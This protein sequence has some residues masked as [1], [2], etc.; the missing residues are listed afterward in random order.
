MAEGS[1]WLLLP[2]HQLSGR[3]ASFPR[4]FQHKPRDCLLVLPGPM[5]VSADARGQEPTPGAKVGFP[6]ERGWGSAAG[7]RSSCYRARLML[8]PGDRGQRVACGT[9]SQRQ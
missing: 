1:L 2:A 7:G 4:E 8:C 5:P 9:V 6:M 3:R